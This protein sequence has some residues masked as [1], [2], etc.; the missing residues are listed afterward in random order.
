MA[1]SRPSAYASSTYIW[2]FN[3]VNDCNGVLLRLRRATQFSPV[4]ASN[5]VKA[6]N[7]AVR[8]LKVYSDRRER[9]S[10]FETFHFVEP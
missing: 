6:A 8:L 9:S 1:V 3:S 7:G 2:S 10:P 4:G 5:V